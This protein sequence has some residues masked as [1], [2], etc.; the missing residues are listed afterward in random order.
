MKPRLPVQPNPD[1]NNNKAVQVIDIQNLPTSLVQCN[2]IHLRSG[3]VVKPIIDDI[4]SFES[5]KEEAKQSKSSNKDAEIVKPPSNKTA[6]TVKPSFNG[7][8]ETTEPPFP[9]HLALTK[10]PNPPSFNLLG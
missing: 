1:P 3:R 9:M 5:D 7:T 2:D 8:D 10:T 4:A 6:E